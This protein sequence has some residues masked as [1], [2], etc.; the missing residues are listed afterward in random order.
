MASN[1]QQIKDLTAAVATLHTNSAAISTSLAE[2]TK[3]FKE[4][5]DP[6]K[7]LSDHV[8]RLGDNLKDTLADTEDMS[9]LLKTLGKSAKD[10][11]RTDWSAPGAIDK[12]NEALKKMIKNAEDLRKTKNLTLETEKA[13]TKQIEAMTTAQVKLASGVMLLDDEWEKLEDTVNSVVKGVDSID[14]KKAK[15]GMTSLGSA[16]GSVASVFKDIN[17]FQFKNITDAFSKM[18]TDAKEMKKHMAEGGAGWKAQQDARKI[19]SGDDKDAKRK[20]LADGFEAS[21]KSRMNPMGWIDKGLAK[22]MAR[23]VANGGGQTLTK[24][25]AQGG[26]SITA[27]GGMDVMSMMGKMSPMITVFST[28]LEAVGSVAKRKND[29]YQG[30]GKGWLLA[31]NT[32]V[33]GV[34]SGMIDKLTPEKPLSFSTSVMGMNFDKN[35]EIMK[36]LVENGIGIRGMGTGQSAQGALEGGQATTAMGGI[37]RNSYIFGSNLGMSNQESVALTAKAITEF[38]QSFQQTE[39]LFININKGVSATGLTTT[40]YL[41]LIDQITGQFS[42]FNKTLADT[43]AVITAMGKSGKYTAEYM[44]EMMKAVSGGEKSFEQRAFAYDTMSK[45]DRKGLLDNYRRQSQASGDALAGQLGI[46]SSDLEKMSDADINELVNKKIEGMSDLDKKQY[47]SLQSQYLNNRSN[48][49]ARERAFKSGDVVAMAG[50]DMSVG[51]TREG[52]T[53]QQM[54]LLNVL[55]K[56][57]GGKDISDF[58]DREKRAKII[59]NPGFSLMAQQ[60]GISDVKGLTGALPAA[61]MQLAKEFQNTKPGMK[62]KSLDQ[63]M[64]SP[65]FQKFLSSG[66]GANK[67]AEVITKEM[68]DAEE[69]KSADNY[70]SITD[71]LSIIKNTLKALLDNIIKMLSVVVDIFT[72]SIFKSDAESNKKGIEIADAYGHTGTQ[73]ER[74]FYRSQAD[75]AFKKVDSDKSIEDAGMR[76]ALK[77]RITQAR[78]E[79]EMLSKAKE[80]KT[81]TEDMGKRL[82]VLGSQMNRFQSGTAMD[83]LTVFDTNAKFT[84]ADIDKHK[85]ALNGGPVKATTLSD[86]NAQ[87]QAVDSAVTA[88]LSKLDSGDFSG[89]L[90]NGAVAG[91]T[92][93]RDLI[94]DIKKYQDDI[95]AASTD[96]ER[97]K[98]DTEF[99]ANITNNYTNVDASTVL[100]AIKGTNVAGETAK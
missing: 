47:G 21:G 32:D 98:V 79:Y 89:F 24:M 2:F 8:K 18:R 10:L 1:A 72:F 44:S 74:D 66:A 75:E 95:K 50:V 84:Q 12:A 11:A 26:G 41:G 31:G 4:S 62:G 100:G 59:S 99:K 85:K 30:L 69:K 20:L 13:L 33:R 29:I 45:D 80:E 40:K 37:M 23:Q 55:V 5:I 60:L 28:L 90:K 46:K 82:A 58:S 3:G 22:V 93:G 19:L 34:Y 49:S 17:A 68:R 51:A 38:N 78:D 91:D 86:V 43:V 57:M 87:D 63:V 83:G 36:S 39:D 27:G 7:K 61:Q 42:R 65:E 88:T 94:A 64:Q 67:M 15:A 6:A 52:E 97:A 54:A 56:N 16:L 77:S 25:F 35:L 70:K 9:A 53:A 14:F 81:L 92:L 71:P 96:A 48:L 76:D 73:G